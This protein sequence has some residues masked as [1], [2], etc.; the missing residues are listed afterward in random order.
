MLFKKI[1]NKGREVKQIAIEYQG[2][3]FEITLDAETGKPTG[4]FAWTTD[5]VLLSCKLGDILY[6]TSKYSTNEPKPLKTP[7]NGL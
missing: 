7:K 5:P 1:L 6:A 2:N 3:Y 4:D